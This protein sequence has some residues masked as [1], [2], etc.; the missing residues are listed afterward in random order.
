MSKWDKLILRIKS[1]DRNMR[2]EELQ[3]VLEF[4]GYKINAPRL[5]CIGKRNCRNGGKEA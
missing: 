2:F 1:L 3:K 5:C 4:Y